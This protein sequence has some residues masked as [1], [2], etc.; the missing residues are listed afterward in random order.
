MSKKEQIHE[1]NYDLICKAVNGDPEALDAILQYYDTYINALVAYE[2]IDED[3][4]IYMALDEDMKARL[5][6]KLIE[7]IKKWREKY[8]S[9]SL[10]V[11]LCLCEAP[12]EAIPRLAL[13]AFVPY[14][15][16]SNGTPQSPHTTLTS[17]VA[18]MMELYS[19]QESTCFHIKK[20]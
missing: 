10:S 15:S 16:R 11:L 17:R 5:Q 4:K 14:S 12:A 19:E 8:N 13:F 6:C 20:C 2:A 1:L 3:G 9:D 18:R 7:A